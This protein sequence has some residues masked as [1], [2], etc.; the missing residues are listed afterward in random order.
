[1]VS[2]ANLQ[3]VSSDE[4]DDAPE[5]LPEEQPPPTFLE[6]DDGDGDA[7][8]G[9]EDESDDFEETARAAFAA[10]AG[11][12]RKVASTHNLHELSQGEAAATAPASRARSLAIGCVVF[13]MGVVFALWALLLWRPP[14]ALS[15]C[16][17]VSLTTAQR[18]E[19]PNPQTK[20]SATLLALAAAI[21]VAEGAALVAA[22]RRPPDP[23]VPPSPFV[24]GAAEQPPPPPPIPPLPP[25]AYYA[26]LAPLMAPVTLIAVTLNWFS[27]KLFRHN[28]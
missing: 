28:S 12:W 9:G 11:S 17:H 4:D 5:P 21:V 26:Y 1:M 13:F 10:L 2:A 27:L 20:N 18:P 23:P 8:N 15:L 14:P 19:R 6:E 3:I 25:V 22:A 7:A 24:P 16:R